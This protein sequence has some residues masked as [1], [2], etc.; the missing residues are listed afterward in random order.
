MIASELRKVT[1]SIGSFPSA[2]ELRAVGRGDLASIL[3]KRGGYS[4]WAERLGLSR[5]H[6]DSD[7]GWD[8]EI[9]VMRLFAD[10]G[11]SCERTPEKKAPYD[12]LAGGV[13]RVDVKSAK[14]AEYAGST[15]PCR[16]WFFRIGKHPQADLIVLYKLDTAGI[17]AVPWWD[18]PTTNV[19]ISV[20]G[21]KYSPYA[22]N[23]ELIRK[24]IAAREAERVSILTGQRV[25]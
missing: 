14:F 22:D 9:A 6:S 13:L 12:L 16:G 19:T 3:A 20:G 1:G 17:H 24:M 25:A 7:T 8:G 4:F 11:I 23:W 2:N 18:C 15:G 21:G 10:R 5:K